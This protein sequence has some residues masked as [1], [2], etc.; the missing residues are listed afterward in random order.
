MPEP[1][2]NI[3]SLTEDKFA[4]RKKINSKTAYNWH[5]VF[6]HSDLYV[7]SNKNIIDSLV[8]YLA[9]FYQAI[10]G[11]AA[12]N[13]SFLKSLSPIRQNPAYP[14]IINE[15]IRKSALYGVGPMASVAGAACDYIG[16]RLTSQCSTIIIE[17]GGDVFIKCDHDVIAGIY[18]RDSSIS[19]KL[20]LR[21][22]HQYTPC[23]LCSSS[24]VFGH[25]LSLGK[26]DLAC[27]LATTTIAADAAVTAM[28]N[29]ISAEND[30]QTAINEFKKMASIRGLL[31]IKDKKIGIWGQLELVS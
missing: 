15:M 5:V 8:K 2:I 1:D 23:G 24:G 26:S 10:E 4:Y 16:R 28:A 21:I 13:P 29:R 25:S 27:V 9:E 20:K 30:I 17:N 11:V 7:A 14:P 3:E 22:G 31:A 18:T 19:E 12:G 6:R